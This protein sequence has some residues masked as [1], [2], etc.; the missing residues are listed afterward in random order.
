M[1]LRSS[2]A[3]S[4]YLQQRLVRKQAQQRFFREIVIALN[5]LSN[6]SCRVLRDDVQETNVS[7]P[8]FYRIRNHFV[9][10]W[11]ANGWITCSRF[12]GCGDRSITFIEQ[13]Q[14]TNSISSRKLMIIN[15][16]M[17][18]TSP[19]TQILLKAS[20]RCTSLKTMKQ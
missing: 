14:T 5:S 19:Q 3:T 10:C 4:R 8:H 13:Y 16:R 1:P 18:T 11:V 12:K 20:L 17:W 9:R 6:S 15:C 7:I 2:C